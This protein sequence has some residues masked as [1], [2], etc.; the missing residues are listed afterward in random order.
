M[1]WGRSRDGR[2]HLV[3]T[4]PQFLGRPGVTPVSLCGTSLESVVGPGI[5]WDDSSPLSCG[6]CMVALAERIAVVAAD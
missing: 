3:Q 2:R 6:W 5:T 4:L 1:R